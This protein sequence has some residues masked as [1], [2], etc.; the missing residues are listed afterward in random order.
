MLLQAL[1]GRPGLPGASLLQEGGMGAHA[2]H[3]TPFHYPPD[4]PCP[5]CTPNRP[6]TWSSDLVYAI[7]DAYPVSPGHTLV[8][9]R[10]HVET[11]FD[12]SPGEQQEIWRAV[13]ELKQELDKRLH[14]DGYNVGINAGRA[15]GQTV[16]H[17]HVHLIPR[18][19]DDVDDPSGGVRFVIPERGDY[20]SPGR[21]PRVR[22]PQRL[23]TG[24]PGDPFLDQLAP[25]LSRATEIAV[26]A[27]FVR[28]SGVRAIS[29]RI[30]G[31]LARGARVRVLTGDYLNLTQ[32][33]ALYP[34]MDLARACEDDELHPG[35][36]EVRVTEVDG[37]PGRSRSFHPKA[38]LFS[39]P[40]FRTA[41]VGSSNLSWAALH[42][43][44]EWN[45]RVDRHL[46]A[47]A[48]DEVHTA[49]EA[50]WAS[51]TIVN[52]DWLSAY[53][54][55]ARRAQ[56]PLPVDAAEPDAPP[57]EPRD[58]QREALQAL[59]KSRDQGRDRALVVMAT[60][61]GKTWMA[62]FDLDQIR[63][64]QGR[65]PRTLW[66][67]HRRELL[68]QAA[69]TLRRLFPRERFGWLVGA[70]SDREGD[71]LFASVQKL[72]RPER[73]AEFAADDFDVLVI[74]EV[75]HAA[76]DSYRRLLDHFRPRFQLGLTATPRR[77]DTRDVLGLFDDHV[78]FEA[79]LGRGIA[80]QHLVPFA[81]FGLA[82]TTDYQPIP[83]RNRRFEPQALAKAVQTQ[84]RMDR[85]WKGWTEHPGD[86]TLIFCCSIAHSEFVRDW[87]IEKGVQAL[88]VHSG[89]GSHDRDEALAELSHGRI[90]AICAVDLFNEGI[91][92]PRL[93]RVVMLRPTESPVVFLQQ[94]GRGLRRSPG[95]EQLVVIDFVGNHRVF[96]D[97][98]RT[99]LNLGGP[100]RP[101]S[102]RDLVEGRDIDLPPGCSVH[103]DLAA[104]DLLKR[105]LPSGDA[106][107]LVRMYRDLRE[108]R[109]ERP[110]AGELARMGFN[111]AS[112]RI[113]S[114]HGSWLGFVAAEG[115]L[116]TQQRWAWSTHERWFTELERT[117]MT[118]S[119]KMVTLRALL[120][121]DAI[122]EGLE[123]AELAERC[124]RILLR[125]PELFR[126]I[127]GVRALPD[128]ARPTPRAWLA[129]WRTNPVRA[130]ENVDWFRLEA[131]LFKPRFEVRP[132]HRAAFVTLT[133][134]LVDWRL[135]RY[136]R[137]RAEEA[138]GEG[139]GRPAFTCKLITNRRH[140]ILKLPSRERFPGIPTGETDVRLQDG[141][142]WRFRFASLFVN[143]AHPV[144]SHVNELPDLLRNWFG[145]HAG[146]P[147]TTHQ[148]RFTP[149]AD[150][151]RVEPL[152]AVEDRVVP[153]PR[154]GQVVGYPTLKAA[155]GFQLTE[156][157]GQVVDGEVVRLP[158]EFAPD[159][160]AV[161]VH[162]DSMS[163]GPEPDRGF[164]DGDWAVLRWAQSRGIEAHLDRVVLVE[165]GHPLEA[166]YLLKRLVRGRTGIVLR[167]YNPEVPDEPAGS[168]D[169]V[170]AAVTRRIRPEELAPEIGSSGSTI[171]ELFGLDQEPRSPGARVDGHLFLA[172]DTPG[173]AI[174]PT[175]LVV[176]GA[177]PRASEPAY[178]CV[179]LGERWVYR[180]VGRNRDGT[181]TIPEM[182]FP[183][184]AALRAKGARGGASRPLPPEWE[185]AARALVGRLL[186]DPGVGG[187]VTRG[188]RVLL[189][190]GQAS[191]GGLVVRSPGAKKSRTVSL[192]DLG[193]VLCARAR[194][195]GP[196][197]EGRVNEFRYLVGT[198]R[199]STR[200]IDT[201]HAIT[202]VTGE[203]SQGDE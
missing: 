51:A 28:A 74:D 25:L 122:W 101:A 37:L 54:E 12:A 56:R 109:G 199:K 180:G 16:M 160:L 177:P 185:T 6:P 104:I 98:V 183:C 158:G 23:T 170:I 153:L 108:S 5:F 190:D 68:L 194:T 184:W 139:H 24:G 43:A 87:L 134:E 113:R 165:R 126:D 86:R 97:R 173:Q 21:L 92:L 196:I 164:D 20:R 76:A 63:R 49:F 4:V 169:H 202:L 50:Q 46:D 142:W 146:Q 38:W 105:L 89:P 44:V 94:L 73:L 22:S 172:L 80:L 107:V 64:D 70:H 189:I 41:F 39:G 161:R 26:L 116:D 143:V 8:I 193:W 72:S 77:A 138:H 182:D 135:F 187:K 178:V 128:P 111:P 106:D 11:W 48:T 174:R 30:E 191:R 99:L 157:P 103:V 66:V 27:A 181:W 7:E 166:R 19:Q 67:A 102:P 130:W 84:E 144:G 42:D 192:L 148:V 149:T 69:Q 61:L 162:G 34:L 147:G 90:D 3:P 95:K 117:Q 79:D 127:E 52:E 154:R 151:W 163:Y 120:E 81:Y 114:E 65:M 93:D 159:E 75:H 179:R 13:A 140:P 32:A 171:A 137:R 176:R 129:Y 167:S 36:L 62:A 119:F 10:R 201:G 145:P 197:D 124:H 115:D 155:A 121:A 150:G 175:S 60:G 112:A 45:L 58:I 47:A 59:Q 14:P 9:P 91:D 82:D 110:T 200:W 100:E 186:A 33:E 188:E 17:L 2:D 88:A 132:E 1:M 168:D 18:F 71:V 203:V 118:K 57:P 96:L 141:R 40:D 83:W 133:A 195:D 55:R 15:A 198:P 31:A 29:R 123:E 85:L 35:T 78:P 131:G 152:E 136:R 53:T 156:H 125:S